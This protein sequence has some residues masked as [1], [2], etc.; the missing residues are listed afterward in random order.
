MTAFVWVKFAM[1]RMPIEKMLP[2]AH[3]HMYIKRVFSILS[4]I[5]LYE[6]TAYQHINVMFFRFINEE[7]VQIARF[8][9]KS[10]LNAQ[11]FCYI[12]DIQFILRGVFITTDS[13]IS[14]RTCIGK[15]QSQLFDV[16]P[17]LGTNISIYQ[18]NRAPCLPREVASWISE[19]LW[20]S[21]RFN[22]NMS[23]NYE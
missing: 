9:D 14:P 21:L 23:L 10:C 4:N 5:S 8:T 3:R 20:T 16:M 17:C 1:N 18:Q 12:A 13:A 2:C 11:C 19:S 7:D 15:R 22:K 6:E